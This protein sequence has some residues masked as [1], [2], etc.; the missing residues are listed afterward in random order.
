MDAL[1]DITLPSYQMTVLTNTADYW[2]INYLRYRP[3]PTRG[4]VGLGKI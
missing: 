3:N 2:T 4:W 1:K